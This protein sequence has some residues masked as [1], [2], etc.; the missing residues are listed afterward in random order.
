LHLADELTAR[1]FGNN[2]NHNGIGR[3]GY[4][5]FFFLEEVNAVVFFAASDHYRAFKPDALNIPESEYG[6]AFIGSRRYLFKIG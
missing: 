1:T 3:S 5:P 2:T 4:I 6:L